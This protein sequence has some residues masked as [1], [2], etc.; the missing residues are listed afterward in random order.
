MRSGTQPQMLQLEPNPESPKTAT[1]GREFV[2]PTEG[3]VGN[4]ERTKGYI[5][6]EAS[7]WSFL[8]VEEVY[9]QGSQNQL[10]ERSTE[11]DVFLT[12]LLRETEGK[13]PP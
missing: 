6:K 11:T 8:N 9:R 2:S 12:K 10:C 5:A 1:M 4:A 7:F 13:I 3:F